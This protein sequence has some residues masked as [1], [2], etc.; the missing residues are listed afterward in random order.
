MQHGQR[1]Q[2]MKS[3]YICRQHQDVLFS[4]LPI[5]LALLPAELT[6]AL[7]A[8]LNWVHHVTEDGCHVS[9][10]EKELSNL[11]RG[12]SDMG[13]FAK[14]SDILTSFST[15]QLEVLLKFD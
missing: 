11:D 6:A 2:K 5:T 9:A 15:C 1:H 12:V 4:F 3:S 10:P 8:H 13:M 7:V 14:Q